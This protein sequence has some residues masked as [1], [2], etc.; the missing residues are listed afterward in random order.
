MT[1]GAEAEGEGSVGALLPHSLAFPTYVFAWQAGTN[2][3]H[4]P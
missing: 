2:P 3:T 1:G 4:T